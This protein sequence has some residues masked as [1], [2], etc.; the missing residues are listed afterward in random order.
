[1]LCRTRPEPLAEAPELPVFTEMDR[2]LAAE[3]G[4]V[5]VS[6]PTASHL[7]VALPAAEAG[8]DLFI[9]K[10]LSHSWDN[11]EAL[12][13]VVRRKQL[14]TLV[15]FDLRFEP[16]LRKVRSLLAD[17]HWRDARATRTPAGRVMTA[18]TRRP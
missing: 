12:L 2:A 6:N 18:M 8:C 5:V 9:E 13:A 14:M 3:P 16:G 7:Q 15:G 17:L 11:V 10:P 4:L 1:M